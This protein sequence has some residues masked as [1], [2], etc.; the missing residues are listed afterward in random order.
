[1]GY[2]KLVSSYRALHSLMVGGMED[3]FFYVLWKINI[4]TKAIFFVWSLTVGILP[5]RDN[6]LRIRNIA[7]GKMSCACSVINF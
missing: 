1:M 5:T 6:K 2:T 4:P 3:K 7:G